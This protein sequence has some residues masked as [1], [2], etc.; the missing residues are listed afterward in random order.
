M[1]MEYRVFRQRYGYAEQRAGQPMSCPSKFVAYCCCIVTLALHVGFAEAAS[2]PEALERGRRLF[3]GAELL[4]G[5]IAGHSSSLPGTFAACARCHTDQ[6]SPRLAGSLPGRTAP[7]IEHGVLGAIR[8]RRGGPPFAYDGDS[9]CHTL[10]TGIDPQYVVLTRT[11]PRFDIDDMQCNALWIYL[12]NDGNK[13]ERNE[14][15]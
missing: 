9:F 10:R 15:R 6:D 14:L 4:Q 13:N 1:R 7:V 3:Q 12:K 11:M 5:R 8:S 2:E